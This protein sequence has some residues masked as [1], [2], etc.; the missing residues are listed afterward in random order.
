MSAVNITSM[1]LSLVLA[2][3]LL[4]IGINRVVINNRYL[5]HAVEASCRFESPAIDTGDRGSCC[6][7][8]VTENNLVNYTTKN[9]LMGTFTTIQPD[10]CYSRFPTS[11]SCKG[12]QSELTAGTACWLWSPNASDLVLLNGTDSAAVQGIVP[13]VM[14]FY[15]DI[16]VSARVMIGF[17]AWFALTSIVN[18]IGAFISCCC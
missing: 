10:M 7:I 14:L 4:P 18:L 5:Y 16:D 6:G 12:Q 17:G 11:D 3:V 2:A 8:V 9:G 13:E 15:V 1:V